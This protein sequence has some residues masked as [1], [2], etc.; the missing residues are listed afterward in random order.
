[1]LLS[2]GTTDTVIGTGVEVHK[3]LGPGL[4]ESAYETAL[5]RELS[6]RSVAF[7]RQVNLPME[8]KGVKLDCGYRFTDTGTPDW[9]DHRLY[10]RI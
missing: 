6:L 10:F 7:E 5:C 9:S 1:M 2:E 3:T 4:L 8:Y